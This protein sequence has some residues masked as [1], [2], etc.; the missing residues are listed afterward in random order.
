VLSEDIHIHC[1]DG[2]RKF[3]GGTWGRGIGVSKAKILKESRK[4]NWN[5]PRGGEFKPKSLPWGGC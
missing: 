5:F 3:Q 4:A 2:N 1:M